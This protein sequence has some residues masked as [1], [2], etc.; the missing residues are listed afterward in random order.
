MTP[1]HYLIC[2]L[3]FLSFS[4]H[5]QTDSADLPTLSQIN[6]EMGLSLPVN[7]VVHHYTKDG[8]IDSI[9]I[10]HANMTQS[11]FTHWIS[12]FYREENH[13][14]KEKNEFVLIHFPQLSNE[15]KELLKSEQ[16]IFENGF[17][18]NIG[19]LPTSTKDDLTILIVLHQT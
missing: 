7:T 16:I 5:S 2:L 18:L 8:G 1:L 13:F 4:C 3:C 14:R 17:I 6:E 10:V 11:D 12:N 9:K 15:Q 19:V